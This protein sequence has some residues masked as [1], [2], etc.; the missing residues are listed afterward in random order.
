M[1]GQRAHVTLRQ[2]NRVLG[3]K[4]VNI[5]EDNF[6]ETIEWMT[7]SPEKGL[8]RFTIELNTL[9]G[10]RTQ[11]NN[12]RDV[13]IDIIDGRENILILA[14]SPHPD[15]KALRSIISLNDNFELAM[16]ILSLVPIPSELLK[17]KN[18]LVIFNKIPYLIKI[19]QYIRIT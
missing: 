6:F 5:A 13:Y 11:S 7:T 4:S 9:P 2:G 1:R 10:E 8:Q 17:K 16:H 12:R 3:T 18:D 19:W 14:L 15:L